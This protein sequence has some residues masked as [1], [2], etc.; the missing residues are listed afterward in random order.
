[1]RNVWLG[2]TVAQAMSSNNPGPSSERRR[3]PEELQKLVSVQVPA[4]MAGGY[5]SMTVELA[6][7]T[8]CADAVGG[9]A[10]GRDSF[11]D[12]AQLRPQMVE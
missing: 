10:M 2:V 6:S 9:W 8:R 1:M 4:A 11:D 7:P 12:E 3:C 5:N